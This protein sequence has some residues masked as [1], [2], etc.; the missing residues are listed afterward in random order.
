MELAWL[1]GWELEY[2]LERE[3]WLER[4]RRKQFA[5]ILIWEQEREWRLGWKLGCKLHPHRR[6]TL[7]YKT[8]Q[9]HRNKIHSHCHKKGWGWGW[10]QK[11]HNTEEQNSD[12][13]GNHILPIYM[14]QDWH[15]SH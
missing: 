1:R 6:I 5:A 12:N 8:H 13:R 4:D 15:M 11:V 14:T 3:S 2:W 7:D 9:N 10:R